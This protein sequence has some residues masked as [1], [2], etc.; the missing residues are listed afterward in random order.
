MKQTF[1]DLKFYLKLQRIHQ[2]H[3]DFIRIHP[4][5]LSINS[6][7][8]IPDIYGYNSKCTKGP[9]Y[10]LNYPGR[11]LHMTRDRKFHSQ[12]RKLWDRAFTTRALSDYETRIKGHF[13]YFDLRITENIGKPMDATD[14]CE[15]WGF[16]VMGDLMFGRP[17]NQL[18]ENKPHMALE[19]SRKVKF[20]G[21]VTLY[22]YWVFMAL[23]RLPIV[24]GLRVKWINWCRSQMEERRQAKPEVLDLYAHLLEGGNEKAGDVISATTDVDAVF[25]AELAIVAGSDTSS[26]TLAAVVY[27]LAKH[28]HMQPRLQEEVDDAMA[29]AGGELSYQ[30][31]IKKPLLD[32]IINEALRL[33]PPVPPGLQRLTPPEGVMIAGRFIPG[34]TL[35]SVPCWSVQHDPRNFPKP[36]EFIPERWSTMPELALHKEAL[37][38][39]STGTYSCVGKPLAMM[40][41]RLAVSHIASRFDISLEDPV[42]SVKLFEES[43]GWQD[44][45]TTR[46]PPVK[47]CF[48]ER[49][50]IAGLGVSSI[51]GVPGDMNLELLDYI[52]EVDQLSW[53][54]TTMGVGELSAI[55]GVAGAYT[56]Q[57]KTINIVGT[58][59]T[60]AQRNRSM[61]HHCL[62][63]DPDHRIY[64]KISS[65]VRAAHCWLDDID[66][67]TSEIDRVLRTCLDTSLP[68][69]IFVPT[70]FVHQ[71]VDAPLPLCPLN[72][73]APTPALPQP[74]IGLL[75]SL[76]YAARRPIIIVDALVARHGATQQARALLD[77]LRHVP[78]VST[79]MGKGIVRESAPYFLGTYVGRLSRPPGI[80]AAVEQD[81]DL[82]LD[83][84]PLHSDSNTG[85][86]S[87]RIAVGCTLV[88]VRPHEVVVRGG[89]SFRNDA[90]IRAL[91]A[92]VV[93]GVDVSKLRAVAM[94]E[95]LGVGVGGDE[96]KQND[97]EGG[98]T[99]AWI[100]PRI[101]RF[102]RPGDVLVAES[103]TAQF[104]LSDVA[105]PDDVTYVTQMYY[106]S[107]GLVINNDG[108]TIERAIHGPE[109]VYNDIAR[110]DWQ[111]MLSFFG[112]N[113]GR[114]RSREAR[115]KR[116]L[117]DILA[118]PQY[119]SPD[120][121]QVLEVHMGKMDVPRL[122]KEYVELVAARTKA[123]AGKR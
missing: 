55:N 53:V 116:D 25:D 15:Y 79:P 37:I 2:E 76:L 85:G 59:S 86:H 80:V 16:D 94:P 74:L 49:K 43:P 6:A 89:R 75:L 102:L 63:P 60:A 12:R 117:E 106:A 36:Y 30:T 110:W 57:V 82:V 83:L 61:I 27:L 20:I 104:G 35:V 18:K 21:G 54:V 81:S 22:S 11:S 17:F 70:D 66:F 39:F 69:Y 93:A 92:G 14:L 48:T 100:W 64:E 41:L 87:R 7:E 107:I 118:L 33:Y 115:T 109:E 1:P 38:P 52:K 19:L 26:A 119:T 50:K 31:L 112:D 47:V 23:Q 28:R 88:E 4:R 113:C 24:S 62:G 42:E 32:G 98:I 9:F 3:G 51:F 13:R 84:G 114:E 120:S 111:L 44:A 67:A 72:T 108:Y 78:A 40:E 71:T 58:T 5:A 105:L 10:D 46:V 8:A 95:G 77:T 56:E 121:I 122:L 90:G 29:T 101:A 103:G 65:H 97:D 123:A 73:T 45:F 99:Q 34:D 68:V 91:L 96:E